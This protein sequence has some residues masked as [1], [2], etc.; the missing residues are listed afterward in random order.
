MK[1]AVLC[2]HK[3][4]ST[5]FWRHILQT[6]A[7]EAGERAVEVNTSWRRFDE[8][9][10]VEALDAADCI[11]DQNASA[12]TVRALE[13]HAG[14]YRGVHLVRDP[15]DV[16]VSAYFSHLYSHVTDGWP[17]LVTHR[18]KLQTLTPEEGLLSEMTFCRFVFDALAGWRPNSNVLELRSEEV[19][20][21][22]LPAIMGIAQWFEWTIP[23]ATIERVLEEASYEKLAGRAK[24][25]EN[26][27]HHYRKGVAG[28]WKNWFTDRVRE[29]FAT[30]YGS[31][32]V[33]YGYESDDMAKFAHDEARSK[34]GSVGSTRS[35][36]IRVGAV[37]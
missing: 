21:D 34:E 22:P 4:A 6:L 18:E 5:W 30:R 37:R 15:R 2:H 16:L 9:A 11:G 35:K 28:D 12:A 10:F 3:C 29:E 31:L 36:E 23:V 1:K 27:H 7:H 33:Q 14:S 8:A 24:G 13:M 19:T 20:A 25:I 26:P 32:L 17:E